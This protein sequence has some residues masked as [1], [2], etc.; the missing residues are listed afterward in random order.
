[1]PFEIVAQIPSVPQTAPSSLDIN[2]LITIISLMITA[3]SVYFLFRQVQI[4]RQFRREDALEK[5]VEREIEGRIGQQLMTLRSLEI[6]LSSEL[7]KLSNEVDSERTQFSQQFEIQKESFKEQYIQYKSQAD[8]IQLLLERAQTLV[9]SLEQATGAIPQQLLTLAQQTDE[10]PEQ[11]SL[12]L[13]ILDHQESDSTVLEFAG[14]LARVRLGNRK[15]AEKL[16]YRAYNED[17]L[18]IGAR[19]EYLHLMAYH[20]EKRLQAEIDIVE[21][22]RN[23]PNNRTVISNL[24]NFFVQIGDYHKLLEIGT[25]LLMSSTH[26]ALLWRN[27][28]VAH[29]ELGH[30]DEEVV[31]SYETAL[32]YADEE[33]YANVAVVYARYLIKRDRYQKAEKTLIKAIEALPTQSPLHLLRGDLY[34]ELKLYTHAQTCF[35]IAHDTARNSTEQQN[36]R[37]RLSSIRLLVTI[38]LNLIVDP[39]IVT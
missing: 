12:L 36:A 38:D 39:P 1:M 31:Q 10:P 25:E 32:S 20:P 21:L 6:S 18:A 3:V 15:L 13:K 28:A 19:A 34:R 5:A 9:P 24:N 35:Q 4:T 23:H 7:E 22:A 14:D 26:V 16:Y 2:S 37:E 11:L 29:T 17:N 33:N 30:S 8:Q 27:I